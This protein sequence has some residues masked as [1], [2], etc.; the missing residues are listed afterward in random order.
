MHEKLLSSY[1]L[2]LVIDRV[3]IDTLVIYHT[4][5]DNNDWSLHNVNRNFLATKTLA[6]NSLSS[7]LLVLARILV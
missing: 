2:R 1:L 3:A 7:E 6:G 5:N 4:G